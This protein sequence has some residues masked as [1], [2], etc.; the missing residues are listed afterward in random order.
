MPRE[1]VKTKAKSKTKPEVLPRFDL[2]KLWPRK[3]FIPW[4]TVSP[5]LEEGTPPP[6]G[7]T[8]CQHSAQML[9]F[10]KLAKIFNITTQVVMIC[11]YGEDR[12]DLTVG[13]QLLLPYLGNLALVQAHVAT[14][15]GS[16]PEIRE[17]QVRKA[18]ITGKGTGGLTVMR[19][20]VPLKYLDSALAIRLRRHP[21]AVLKEAELTLEVKTYRWS[22]ADDVIVGYAALDSAETEKVLAQSVLHRS[23]WTRLAM[24]TTA[25]PP[26]TWV[27]KLDSESGHDYYV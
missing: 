2:S 8:I 20:T 6:S 27:T 4:Q 7:V 22:I 3:D 17:P 26:V 1:E 13:R 14:L 18:N 25:K 12:P 5:A 23:F 19:I 15:D 16:P 24:D 9:E 21:E 10:Q 11:K